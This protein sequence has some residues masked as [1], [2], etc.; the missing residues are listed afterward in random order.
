MKEIPQAYFEPCD[1]PGRLEELAIPGYPKAVVYLPAGYDETTD[2]YSTFYLLHGGG[3]DPYCFFD[4]DGQLKNMLDHMIAAGEMR[5]LIV[6]APTYYP[7]GKN[8]EGI[9]YSAEI[10]REFGPV[11]QQ[12]ILPIVD[13]KYRT[14]PDRH[15]RGIGGCFMGAVATWFVMMAGMNDFYW[16]MPMSGDCWIC[17]ERGGGMHASQTAG[18][19]AVT[20]R[21]KSFF[22]H[23][24]TGGK[25]NAFLNLDPQMQAIREYA[26]VFGKNNVRYTVFP[27]GKQ[28]YT[29]IRR[30]IYNALP[31][32]FT[33]YSEDSGRS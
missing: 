1:Q 3:G 19:L 27:E 22:L 31:E 33:G 30:Y 16:Y 12:T 28:D 26:D 18:L 32:F 11:L 14:V 2:R 10:V 8:G 9:S 25:D 15:H 13:E 21:G 17:G 24:L 29:D 20:L 23:V 5:P 6:V 4:E 7:P